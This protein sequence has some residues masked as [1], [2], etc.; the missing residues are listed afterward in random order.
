MHR[1]FIA[2]VKHNVVGYIALF[3]AL[4]GTSYA[5][6]SLTPGSVT[7]RALARGAVT[8]T[9]LAANSVNGANIVNGTV[10]KADLAAGTLADLANGSKGAAGGKAGRDATGPAGPVGPAGRAGADGSASIIARARATASVTAP[11]GATTSV[12][13]DSGTWNQDPGDVDLVTGSVTIKTPSACTG[14]FGNS[15]IL[16]VDG[17]PATFAVAPTAP[18]SG[19]VSMPIAV[20]AVMEPSS[21]TTHHLTAS[22]ANSCTKAGEDF[23][24]SD[25]KVD[26]VKF[27]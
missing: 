14:S 2:H 10:T 19:T 9:K 12:P 4:G 13:V 11:H 21:S 17:A 15:L 3:A 26:I 25:L 7:N 6:V 8:H 27:H 24:I 23:G 18:P 16:Q 22:L 1:R 5:A 20:M